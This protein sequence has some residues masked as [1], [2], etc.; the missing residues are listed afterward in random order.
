MGLQLRRGCRIKSVAFHGYS[1]GRN[2]RAFRSDNYPIF[3]GP[4]GSNSEGHT[5][6]EREDAFEVTES[7]HFFCR[8][9]C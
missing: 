6:P 9:S 4:L 2:V 8:Q 3:S 5:L 1:G 7:S